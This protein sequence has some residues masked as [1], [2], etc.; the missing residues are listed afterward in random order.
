ME[1]KVTDLHIVE[2]KTNE[3]GYKIYQLQRPLTFTLDGVNYTVPQGFRTDGASIPYPVNKIIRAKRNSGMYFRSA[4]LHDMLYR[5][6]T[7][8]FEADELFFK[9]MVTEGTPYRYSIP[10]Y[11]AVRLFGR[12]RWNKL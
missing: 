5:Q 1:N 11:L 8:R 9:A 3:D 10:F 6:K 12:I 7:N 2:V 4:I